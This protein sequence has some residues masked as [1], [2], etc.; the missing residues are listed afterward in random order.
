[1][2]GGGCALRR[3]DDGG[4]TFFRLPFTASDATC[5]AQVLTFAFP[6]SDVG[7]LFLSGGAVLSTA[8]GGR[9]FTR[10]TAVPGGGPTDVDCVGAD[11]CFVAS[12]STIQ[13]TGDGG[14]SWTQVHSGT[15]ALNSIDVA[16]AKTLYVVG[17]SVAAGR[18]AR[19]A[20]RPGSARRSRA[21][22]RATWARCVAAAPR[23]A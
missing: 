5:S 1:M 21:R 2:A 17:D 16:D 8:D 18:R 12:G 3:S 22:R 9:T 15:P 11:T 7:Y 10:R 6:T 20:G 14:V 4:E 13:R 19:T 23:P